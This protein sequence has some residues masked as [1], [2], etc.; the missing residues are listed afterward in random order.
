MGLYVWESQDFD[1]L[2]TL[3]LFPR[4]EFDISLSLG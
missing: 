1:H 2:D 3:D 4:G